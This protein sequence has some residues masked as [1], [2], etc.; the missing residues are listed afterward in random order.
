MNV[1]KENFSQ[2]VTAAHERLI[3]ANFYFKEHQEMLKQRD[4]DEG[5]L[6]RK[7]N[8]SLPFIQRAYIQNSL[9]ILCTLCEKNDGVNFH[10]IRLSLKDCKAKRFEKFFK[11]FHRIYH[12]IRLIRNKSI[13][14]MDSENVDKLYK[15]A[16]VTYKDIE[17]LLEKSLDYLKYLATLSS[18]IPAEKLTY[19]YNSQF[20]IR[21]IYDKLSEE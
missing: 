19:P 18:D 7:F 9:L 4:S 14:H 2:L 21:Q 13:A 15:Q 17:I 12:A 5:E 3:L 6:Y 16:N 8:F 20:G 11:G 10:K 1:S